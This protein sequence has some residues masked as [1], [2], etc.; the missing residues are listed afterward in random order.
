MAATPPLGDGRGMTSLP[1]NHKDIADSAYQ[2]QRVAG[3]VQQRASGPR[4]VTALPPALAHFEEALDRLATGVIKAAQAV[5]DWP[6]QS[7][8]G[9]LRPPA[10]ALRWHLFHLAARLRG[11]QDACPETRRWARELLQ[12]SDV[13][14]AGSQDACSPD[15]AVMQRGAHGRAVAG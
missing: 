8:G 15:E 9:A 7:G 14:A 3:D 13:E 12:E 4:V 1:G 5:E 11:A 2:L 10:R 6:E